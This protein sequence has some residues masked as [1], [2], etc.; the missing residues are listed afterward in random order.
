MKKKN[1]ILIGLLIVLLV[2]GIFLLLGDNNSREIE[3]VV[4]L[5]GADV[6]LSMPEIVE[7]NKSFLI[8]VSFNTPSENASLSYV[9]LPSGF[10]YVSGNLSSQDFVGR[11]ISYSAEVVLVKEGKWEI[12][13]VTNQA[14]PSIDG[15]AC[16][17]FLAENGTVRVFG[18]E[19]DMINA[20][21]AEY[22][23]ASVNANW[24]KIE[25]YDLTKPKDG[26]NISFPYCPGERVNET[27]CQRKFWK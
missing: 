25:S 3:E 13:V 19:L 5:Y 11:R 8:D 2:F 7:F 12:C 17:Y 18:S 24:G 20:C 1:K 26:S 15:I 21:S 10:E 22:K 23:R 6:K 9:F 27:H 14:P 16:K 4:G